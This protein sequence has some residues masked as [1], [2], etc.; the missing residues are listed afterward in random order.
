MLAGKHYC[1]RTLLP[2]LNCRINI[3][4][5]LL[6]NI[7]SIY[8][9]LSTS[10]H[11]HGRGRTYI[12]HRTPHPSAR[13]ISTPESTIGPPIE[14]AVAGET[15]LARREKHKGDAEEARARHLT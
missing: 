15:A 1:R 11:Q 12:Q 5:H 10:K 9:Y 6:R 13:Q 8:L 7:L 3:A 2:Y 4:F 14:V